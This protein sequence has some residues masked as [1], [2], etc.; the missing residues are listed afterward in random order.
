MGQGQGCE[1]IGGGLHHLQAALAAPP[2]EI[3][4]R[5]AAYLRQAGLGEPL[6]QEG[7]RALLPGGA[8]EPWAAG[9][10]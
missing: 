3:A 2:A 6:R 7:S 4:E 8:G 9:V 10:A 5:L 1:A